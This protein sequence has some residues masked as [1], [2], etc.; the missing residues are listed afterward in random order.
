MASPK[1]FIGLVPPK[2]KRPRSAF[3]GP[4]GLKILLRDNFSLT[5]WLCT[6]AVAQSGLLLLF[7]RIALVPAIAVLFYRLFVTYAMTVG[8]MR[9]PYMDGVIMNKFAAQFPD[10]AGHYGAKPASSDVVV[11]LIG[12]RCN[13]P[14]GLFA[15]GF[16]EFGAYFPRMVQDLEAHEDEFGF[17]GMTSWI[18][19]SA[20][21][22]QNEMLMVGY[23]R[24][25]EGLHK[26][27]HSPLHREAWVW[28]N[29]MTKKY[30]HISIYHE[31]YHVPQAH[32]EAI[33]SNSHPGGIMSTTTSFTDEV[34]GKKMWASPIVD[35]SRGQL[36]TSAGRM[37]R[38]AGNEHDS[39]GP[40]PYS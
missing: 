39:Y 8:W 22:T 33:Y 5:T 28:F 40:D 26:F 4:A 1:E 36:K 31:T 12:T 19:S 30:P 15:P 38:S 35:A 9:N 6:G 11:F 21:E 7:G 13:H 24:T 34:T 37:S 32:Y 18:N 27:A 16:K 23:F 17:L 2:D 14:L 25:V 10:T 20:R 3:F 29:K